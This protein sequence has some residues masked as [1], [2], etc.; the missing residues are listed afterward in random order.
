MYNV[1]LY[2]VYNLSLFYSF[3]NYFKQICGVQ[4]SLWKTFLQFCPLLEKKPDF[5]VFFLRNFP[6][7]Q[8][9]RFPLSYYKNRLL[10]FIFIDSLSTMTNNLI[11][12]STLRS[13]YASTSS[14]TFDFR[15]ISPVLVK[16]T[17]PL[18]SWLSLISYI[19]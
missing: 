12:Y 18:I 19:S 10:Y 14:S 7:A 3:C 15:S 16:I 8:D 5:I 9:T 1:V 13:R 2:F 6:F 17:E 11:Y 4:C